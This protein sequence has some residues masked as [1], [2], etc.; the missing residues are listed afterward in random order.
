METD[1]NNPFR[2]IAR[3]IARAHA[4]AIHNNPLPLAERPD[5]SGDQ[6]ARDIG[7]AAAVLSAHG[8]GAVNSFLRR[9]RCG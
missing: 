3:N 1:T 9:I 6:L 8:D 4:A 7:R 2:I 5:E